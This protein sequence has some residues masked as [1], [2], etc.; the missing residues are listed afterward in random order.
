VSKNENTELGFTADV[1]A[2]FARSNTYGE[3]IKDLQV[4]WPN[5]RYYTEPGR[6]STEQQVLQSTPL[7]PFK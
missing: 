6:L 5:L 3:A 1:A 2:A 4:G 7:A